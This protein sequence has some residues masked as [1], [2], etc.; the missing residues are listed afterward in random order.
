M[1]E[2]VDPDRG[3]SSILKREIPSSSWYSLV[4]MVAGAAY[5]GRIKRKRLNYFG[6]RNPS[7][8]GHPKWESFALL[9]FCK[10]GINHSSGI[11]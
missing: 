7:V 9:Q 10:V 1:L 6:G 2:N 5:F 4:Q 8:E 11:K 3:K